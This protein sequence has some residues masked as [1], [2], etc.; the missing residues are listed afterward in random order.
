MADTLIGKFFAWT[1]F[2]SKTKTIELDPHC[3]DCDEYD[4]NDGE[5]DE[6]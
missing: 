3:G 5:Y 2:I 6:R 4:S 1:D